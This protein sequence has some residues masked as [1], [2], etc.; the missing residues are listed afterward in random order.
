[1]SV[2]RVS[3][4]LGE[5]KNVTKR[6]G[7]ICLQRIPSGSRSVPE[8]EMDMSQILV[9]DLTFGYEGS[10]DFVF[11]NVSFAVDT[12]WKL[13]FIG[14]NGK[15][16]T[17]FLRLL[18]GEYAFGGRISSSAVFEYFP[19]LLTE[20]QLSQCALDWLWEV[21][22]GSEQWQVIC[23]LAR[24]NA[25]ADL[26]Y[27]P[28]HTLSQGERTKVLLALLFSGENHFCLIDEPTNHLDQDSREVVKQYL[29][30]KRG[31]ILVSHDRDLLDACIDHVLVLNRKTI[32]V[33]SGN[34]SSWWE[35]K[36]GQDHFARMENEKHLREI[37]AMKKA[38]DQTGRWARKSESSKIGR[39]PIKD[40]D[41]CIGSRAYI[42]EK[43]RKLQSRV[44]QYEKR[45][46]REIAARE[47][48]L[49]DIENP[50]PLKLNPL[51]YHKEQLV[52][53]K[54][55]EIGYEGSREA[56]LKDFSFE[57][58][59]GERV[60]LHGGNGCGKSTLI[61][62]LLISV[63]ESGEGEAGLHS[64]QKPGK[65]VSGRYLER[66]PEKGAPGIR[67]GQLQC[68]SGLIVSYVSQDTS[69]LRG[70]IREFCQS[71]G[72]DEGLLCTLLRKLDLDR[73]QFTKNME[74]FSE[75]Q[76][77]KVLLAASLMKPAHLYLW[78]EPLNYID[79]FSRMQIE[80]LLLSCRPTM[81]I[82][83]H[84]VRFREKIAT[85]VIGL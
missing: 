27:R 52:Y 74:E 59:R 84:D 12:A 68:G 7:E 80:E 64:A 10:S 4:I 18:L 13:G 45:M 22:P 38:A 19:Y 36:Q 20:K 40:H 21:K 54:K 63:Q 76:K 47:D 3:G 58:R 43:T 23:E 1:M 44:K 81:L 6:E 67:S 17:T 33:Q 24:M 34:F 30:K 39:D 14:R 66:Q 49:V 82:I 2:E 35:N 32:E 8:G 69:F 57:L 37:S 77:K 72:L 11:E 71:R 55:L 70:G 78:D 83:E 16:K 15:G 5:K 50:V 73:V 31:F 79:V 42:G 41:R 46:E 75:G 25:D 62:T 48:L 26:L 53:G 51:S 29:K 65:E 61:K 9:T 28:F 85:R 60:F 56:V